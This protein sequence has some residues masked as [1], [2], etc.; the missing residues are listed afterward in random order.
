MLFYI[1]T[2]MREKKIV[3]SVHTFKKQEKWS[4]KK[5]LEK[6]L[7][8]FTRQQLNYR[9]SGNP[10]T[11]RWLEDEKVLGASIQFAPS[12]HPFL[13]QSVAAT[14]GNGELLNVP[15]F[16]ISTPLNINW[17]AEDI[18]CEMVAR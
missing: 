13:L 1:Q 16:S 6:H 3:S 12:V 10:L 7:L 2:Y 14:A 15:R 5:H 4:L 11:W 17:K 9:D 8:W 18:Q